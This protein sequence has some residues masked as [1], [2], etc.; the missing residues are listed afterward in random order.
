VA[1]PGDPGGQAGRAELQGQRDA[2]ADDHR[3]GRG[4]QAD[5]EE[6]DEEQRQQYQ[7]PTQAAYIVEA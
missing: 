1:A 2:Q 6:V 7:R 5:Q 3:L 4:E